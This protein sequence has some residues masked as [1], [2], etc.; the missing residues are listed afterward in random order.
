MGDRTERY[1]L[2]QTGIVYLMRGLPS[3]GKSH[4]ARRLAGDSGRVCE[5]DEFFRLTDADAPGG[6]GLRHDLCVQDILSLAYVG[7]PGTAPGAGESV[8]TKQ[9]P[10]AAVR[11]TTSAESDSGQMPAIG[12]SWLREF[13][14]EMDAE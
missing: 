9:W 6:S 11:A 14:V 5:T 13:L 10:P 12:T 7:E 1:G 8:P 3:T 4:T 2:E